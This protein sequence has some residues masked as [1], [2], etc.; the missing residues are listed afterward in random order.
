M[1][2]K[3]ELPTQLGKVRQYKFE[4]LRRIAALLSDGDY[5]VLLARTVDE[6]LTAGYDVYGDASWRKSDAEL[7]QELLEELADAVVYLSV[8]LALK[9]GA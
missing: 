2:G 1:N 5:Q 4:A 6:R 7:S 3:I 9:E 8:L